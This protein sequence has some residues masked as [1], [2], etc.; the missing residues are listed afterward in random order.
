MKHFEDWLE[1][2]VE[3]IGVT[4]SNKQ[5]LES[6]NR[7]CKKGTALTDRQYDLTKKLLQE[8]LQDTEFT[9]NEPLKQPLRQIDRSQ[10]V[11]LV[12]TVDV[13]GQDTVYE[14]YK[15]DWKWLK[16]RFPFS[17]KF[18]VLVETLA[19]DY[20]KSYYHKRGSHE[21]FF[22]VSES[23]VYAVIDAFINKK[24]D[25][26]KELVETY[27]EIKKIKTQR[28]QHEP[29]FDNVQI[30]N[31]STKALEFIH[32]EIDNIEDNKIKLIDRH[33]RYGI[34]VETNS[35]LVSV[36][37]R[38][39]HRNDTYI[40][41]DPNDVQVDEI[42][43]SINELD[44]FP[45]LVIL[46][47]EDNLTQMQK[48]FNAFGSVSAKNQCALFRV[49]NIDD[50]YNVNN[51]IHEKSLNNYLDH[52]TKI[53]YISKYKLPKLLLRNEWKPLATLMLSSTRPNAHITNYIEDVC[54]LHIVN[55]NHLTLFRRSS[56][57]YM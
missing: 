56:Y 34:T 35:E 9:G 45:L 46:D 38:I 19:N 14:S 48:V 21:H 54:D 39:A 29:L 32:S 8:K 2:C 1:H 20:R 23:T 30:K 24:F 26:D 13:Y 41:L 36:T 25:I 22:K 37:N 5:I 55:D 31:L 28:Q 57:V 10:Y 33:R 49:D 47:R 17:K 15:T 44:R 7:Q 3:I 18:I 43:H 51:F 52:N 6:I 42:A 4:D 12:E 40:N 53:V 27:H 16:V 50:E 11:K